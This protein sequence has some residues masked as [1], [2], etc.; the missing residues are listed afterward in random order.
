M[1]QPLESIPGNGLWLASFSKASSRMTAAPQLPPSSSIVQ[2]QLH[3]RQENLTLPLSVAKAVQCA[4]HCSWLQGRRAQT[5]SQGQV[6]E[7]DGRGKWLLL[8]PPPE[9]SSGAN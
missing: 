7:D 3:P 6:E 5:L 8:P 9:L 4:S 2:Q 1:V